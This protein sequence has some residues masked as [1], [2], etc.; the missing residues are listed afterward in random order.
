[1][2]SVWNKMTMVLALVMIGAVVLGAS[3]ASAAG[4]DSG[5]VNIN[6]ASVKQLQ[7]LSGIGVKKAKAI[8]DY[9]ANR[10]FASV[11]ELTKVKGIGKRLIDKLRPNL[12]VKGET[13]MKPKPRKTRKKSS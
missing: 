6:T 1:M 10:P 3:P 2:K 12:A 9:R 8:V 5:V 13:T 7:S 4:T 11:E